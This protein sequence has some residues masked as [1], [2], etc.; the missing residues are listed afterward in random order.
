MKPFLDKDFLLTSDAAKTLYHEHAAR[1][2]IVDYHCH[3]N[4]AEIADD[5]RY[6]SIT[7][8]AKARR[9]SALSLDASGAAAVFRH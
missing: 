2:P 5:R 6:T 7:D 9:Q 1:M 8:G 3:I 4:P